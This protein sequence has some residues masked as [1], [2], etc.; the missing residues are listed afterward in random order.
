[1]SRRS[2]RMPRSYQRD[3]SSRQSSD[4]PASPTL[5]GRRFKSRN[6]NHVHLNQ[7]LRGNENYGTNENENLNKTN[8]NRN[9]CNN[10]VVLLPL[11][12]LEFN[13]MAA[14]VASQQ[15]RSQQEE[16]EEEEVHHRTGHHTR[17]KYR[18]YQYETKHGRKYDQSSSNDGSGSPYLS[19]GNTPGSKVKPIAKHVSRQPS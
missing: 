13:R 10:A 15:Q 6:L 1:M 16:Q 4:S 11:P 9:I 2:A 5:Q 18:Q 8:N 14:Q 7:V 17:H 12:S 19:L 3:R